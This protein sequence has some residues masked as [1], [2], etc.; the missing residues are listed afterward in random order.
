MQLQFTIPQPIPIGLCQC[1]CG[2]KTSIV[3]KAIPVRGYAK[4]QYFRFAPNHNGHK[5]TPRPL[6]ERFWSKVNKNGTIPPHCPN[7]GECWLWTGHIIVGGYGRLSVGHGIQ[8][9]AHRLSYM[10]HY[11]NIPNGCFVCHRCDNP[12]CVRPDHLF[13]G[14]HTDN[15]RDMIAKGRKRNQF[16]P[17]ALRAS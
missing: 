14:T 5:K 13:I 9:F 17:L 8:E 2:Q 7:I 4:G 11:G 3:P 10:L 15:M 16:S 1:G 6:S 12:P